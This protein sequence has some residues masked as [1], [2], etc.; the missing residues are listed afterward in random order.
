MC[1][2]LRL[3]STSFEERF[4]LGLKSA[5]GGCFSRPKS[6][7]LK[8]RSDAQ[9]LPWQALS[10]L[11]QSLHRKAQTGLHQLDCLCKQADFIP[12]RDIDLHV[13]IS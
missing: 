12:G 5:A 10:F 6:A 4:V 7:L 9:C 13:E 11:P 1:R 3:K 2:V 8:S